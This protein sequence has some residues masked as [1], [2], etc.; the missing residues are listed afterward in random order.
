M[1]VHW[2]ALTSIKKPL[3][4]KSAP[5]SVENGVNELYNRILCGYRGFE[6]YKDSRDKKMLSRTLPGRWL[7]FSN[8]T[9]GHFP[10]L[11]IY[12]PEVRNSSFFLLR[13]PLIEQK[14]P[15]MHKITNWSHQKR[16]EQDVLNTP[17]HYPLSI[18]SC[19]S[20]TKS[21]LQFVQQRTMTRDLPAPP[22]SVW[23]S[24]EETTP[25]PMG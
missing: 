6:F 24:R 18:C 2:C 23:P 7:Y 4:L 16:P 25:R 1:I 17:A 20:S 21:T 11:G 10:L 15:Q 12:N 19:P 8:T 13:R 5:Y 9:Y 22:R 3:D 14:L